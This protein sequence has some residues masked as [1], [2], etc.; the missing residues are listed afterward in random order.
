M[1]D[2]LLRAV[3]VLAERLVTLAAQDDGIRD[4]LRSLATAVSRRPSDRHSR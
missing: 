2:D 4:G 3:T 1:N